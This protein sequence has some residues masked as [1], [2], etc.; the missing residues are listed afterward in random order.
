MEY[1]KFSVV[2]PTHNREEFLAGSIQSAL[3]QSMPP[4]EIWVVDDV[5]SPKTEKLVKRIAGKSNIPLH[6]L[7]NIQKANASASRNLAA[8]KV[9]GA[10]I[11]F[12]DDDDF[13][14]KNYLE[15]AGRAIAEK[16][17]DVVL[18]GRSYYY[19][20]HEE[21]PGKIPPDKYRKKDFFLRNPGVA[22]S[23]F[24][25]R[26]DKFHEVGGYS[27]KLKGSGDKDIFMQLMDRGCTF[28]VI[29]EPL[30]HKYKGH[31]DQWTTDPGRILPGVVQFYL[32]YF[33][34]MGPVIHI[35]MILKIVKLYIRSLLK[36]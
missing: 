12:L 20:K 19:D 6:Y 9:K 24:I 32:K 11:A 3:D 1:A 8:Q 25:V 26:T 16:N 22:C 5:P 21:K 14:S 2:I 17:V 33:R 36:R 35:R 31:S 28:H 13:W 30:M 15:E 29:K 34:Q 23:N 10:Y 7:K 18:S 4:L 27:L